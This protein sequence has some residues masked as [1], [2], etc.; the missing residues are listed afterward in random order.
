[1]PFDYSSSRHA[2]LL[3]QFLTQPLFSSKKAILNLIPFWHHYRVQHLERCWKHNSIQL[4]E[5]CWDCDSVQILERCWMK[6]VEIENPP[7]RYFSM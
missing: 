4:L 6:R 1:M 7:N 5:R 2:S 3:G